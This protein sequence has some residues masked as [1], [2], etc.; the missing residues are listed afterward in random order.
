MASVPLPFLIGLWQNT[1]M[2]KN[3]IPTILALIL[4]IALGLVYGWVL[5]P[6]E[7]TDVT[8]ELLRADF[9]TDYVLMVAEAYSSKPDLEPAS[10]KLAILGPEEP[11]V[12]AARAYDYAQQNGYPA[13]DLTLIQELTV[14]LQTWQPLPPTV[15]P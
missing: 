11:A 6:V 10:R 8:P 7:Y 5:S 4:G 9:K 14:A 1:L 13:A 2:Q 3:W 12:L 15:S